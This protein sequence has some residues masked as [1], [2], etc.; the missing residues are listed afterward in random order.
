MI[1]AAAMLTIIF[2]LTQVL[3]AAILKSMFHLTQVLAAA[4]LK[5][6]PPNAGMI[7]TVL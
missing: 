7:L 5:I 3:A 4:I 1:L 6:K 2:H